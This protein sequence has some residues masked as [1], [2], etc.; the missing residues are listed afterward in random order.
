MSTFQTNFNH[1]TPIDPSKIS[2]GDRVTTLFD[3]S[4]AAT[5]TAHK[6]SIVQAAPELTEID[7]SV[8][9]TTVVLGVGGQIVD[10]I[11]D[12][13]PH[14]V[15]TESED[16]SWDAVLYATVLDYQSH[17]ATD[18]LVEYLKDRADHFG[19]DFEHYVGNDRDPEYQDDIRVGLRT[20]ITEI[21][22]G[23]LREAFAKALAE[24]DI[25]LG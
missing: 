4:N 2:R 18:R 24:A 21:M 5:G 8:T 1:T 3:V 25:N 22:D 7:S 14:H 15:L 19:V 17:A 20:L 13:V 16:T 9:I 11:T 10:V 23:T 6:V 12:V